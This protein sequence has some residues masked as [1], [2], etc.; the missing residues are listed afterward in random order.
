MWRSTIRHFDAPI[1]STA[2]DVLAVAYRQRLGARDSRVRRPRCD[3]DR[4]HRVLDPGPQGCDKRQREDESRKRE[5]DVGDAHQRRVE[6]AAGVARDRTD[7]E[8]DRRRKNCYE[9]DHDQRDPRAEDHAR[10]DVAPL[11]VGAEPVRGRRRQQPRRPQIPNVRRIRREAV[12]EDRNEHQ[13]DDDQQ[14]GD[15]E[16]VRDERAPRAV[17]ADRHRLFSGARPVRDEPRMQILACGA[18]DH[19]TR[20]LGSSIR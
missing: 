13:R 15:G 5:K 2:G 3:G 17:R 18:L 11:V 14:T 16:T 6:I 1:I 4:D 19:R 20:V 12:G 9:H 8:P 7:G 10:R